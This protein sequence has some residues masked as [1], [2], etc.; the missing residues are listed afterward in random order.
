MGFL[1]P[2]ARGEREVLV[3]YALQQLSQVRS[4]V[5]GLDDRQLHATPSASALSLG[6]LL[7]HCGQVAVQWSAAAAAAPEPAPDTGHDQSI[8]EC[9]AV[10]GSVAEAL[11]YFDGCVR[12]AEASMRGVRDLEA[13]VPVP[14]A[15]WYPP[16]L[17]TWEARWVLLHI[18]TE[19]ARHAGHADII[20]E[21][22]DGK[23]SY[24][25]NARQ[26]GQLGDDQEYAPYS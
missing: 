24:E 23:G 22:I 17:T 9:Q 13:P 11:A 21:S 2:D 12:T 14:D 19:V 16:G 20:R 8:E 5:H 15:P 3:T 1:T 7:R 10:G 6:A 25:L 18:S 4:T 26:D